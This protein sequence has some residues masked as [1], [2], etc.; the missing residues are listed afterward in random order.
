MNLPHKQAQEYLRNWYES[1][2]TYIR[3]FQDW[4]NEPEK[5][6]HYEESFKNALDY[7]DTLWWFTP[8]H[9][10]DL[11]AKTFGWVNGAT[12]NKVD[13]FAVKL[14]ELTGYRETSL[15]SKILF[16]NKP[17]KI[18]PINGEVRTAVGLKADTYWDYKLKL[19]EFRG[20]HKVEIDLGL[21]EIADDLVLLRDFT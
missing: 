19:E 12:P 20:E 4:K 17:Q 1:E 2:L 6:P 5:H 16:L 14:G 11:M 15:A 18:S 9:V 13:E 8:Q 7:F 3:E 21:K 10:P